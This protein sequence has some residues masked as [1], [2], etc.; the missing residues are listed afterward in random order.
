MTHDRVEGT[1]AHAPT[2]QPS[3]APTQQRREARTA[4]LPAPAAERR[5]PRQLAITI[6]AAV[7]RRRLSALKRTLE[8]MGADPAGN[9]VVPFAALPR[10]HFARFVVLDPTE[11]P[12][13]ETIEPQLLYMADVDEPPDADSALEQCLEELVEVGGAGLD[14]ILGACVGY[15][16]SSRATPS[17]RI[18]FLQE[19]FVDASVSYVNTIGRSVRQIREEEQ[20]RAAIRGFI[21]Q[22]G[23]ELGDLRPRD[24][25]RAIQ[26]FVRARPELSWAL[27]PPPAPSL[28]DRVRDAADLVAVPLGLLAL[29]PVLVPV[30]PLFALALRRQEA[31]EPAPHVMPS[32]ELVLRLAGQEDRGVQN[33]FNA[34]GS[35]GV[36]FLKSGIVRRITADVVLRGAGFAVRHVYNHANLAGV[37]TIH[38]ARWVFIDDRRRRLIFASNYDGSLEA[39]NDDFVDKVWWGLNAVFSNGTGFPSTRWLFFGGARQEQPFKD[40]LRGRQLPS[41]VWY[42]AYPDLTALNV[43]NNARIRAGLRGEMCNE[44]ADAWLRRI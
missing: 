41:Q 7:K 14:R 22:R 16:P 13:G 27:A 8:A 19:H 20:L 31:R 36:G 37:K 39:Y 6:V 18:A 2:V 15:P 42:S 33:Q 9:D 44:E 26:G 11:G 32:R 21:D 28:S 10:T 4:G 38:S 23:D 25:R 34:V 24:A 1:V 35:D 17:Q 29:A 30:V 3:A 40:Y 12:D 5:A 43:E